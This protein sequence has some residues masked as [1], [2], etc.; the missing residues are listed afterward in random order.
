[1]GQAENAQDIYCWGMDISV[2]MGLKQDM[3][4]G[5]QHTALG[6]P[7]PQVFFF[8]F[9]VPCQRHFRDFS[10]LFPLFLL[11][12]PLFLSTT[13]S[14][15]Q[16]KP[17]GRPKPKNTV[18]DGWIEALRDFKQLLFSYPSYTAQ[19]NYDWKQVAFCCT[20]DGEASSEEEKG[21]NLLQSLLLSS[22]LKC[23]GRLP[24]HSVPKTFPRLLSMKHTAPTCCKF[25]ILSQFPAL[26]AITQHRL[27][28]FS[29]LNPKQDWAQ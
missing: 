3:N 8:F 9:P 25:P 23:R 4:Q 28:W 2:E 27:M 29:I 16:W 10:Y 26:S 12:I 14:Q 15:R 5:M 1:M 17:T 11:F 7:Y 22:T 18:T 21:R 19:S 20:G 6:Y 13:G 24:G